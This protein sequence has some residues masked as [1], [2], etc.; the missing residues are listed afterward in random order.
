MPTVRQLAGALT[1]T[2]DRPVDC[3]SL[4]ALQTAGTK[5][6]F[7]W[8]HGHKSNAFLSRLLGADQPLYGLVQ[9]S[10]DGRSAFHRTLPD[11]ATYY[12]RAIESVQ[13]TGPYFLG[14]FCVGGIVAFEIAQ[15]LRRAGHDVRLLALV[16][17]P[18]REFPRQWSVPGR[19]RQGPLRL[20][21]GLFTAIEA[22]ARQ[23]HRALLRT[24]QRLALAREAVQR[25]GHA[26]RGT[27]HSIP[28]D[29]RATY[30]NAI[31][32]RARHRYTPGPYAG[33]IVILKTSESTFDP[34]R[35]WSELA[36][37]GVEIHELPGLHDDV[38]FVDA[39]IEALGAKLKQCLVEAQRARPLAS[40]A[41]RP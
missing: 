19:V 26:I 13:P 7:F 4:V 12:R 22:G 18:Y 9:Q 39:R 3:P 20:V 5:P 41:P 11:I 28:H 2:Q 29:Q 16:D 35:V 10:V 24:T 31:Y 15:Q 17:P 23:G 36:A 30:I 1:E 33:R 21:P 14:G 37:D 6:P 40:I 38:V 8:V 34:Q 32:S 27:E 25:I